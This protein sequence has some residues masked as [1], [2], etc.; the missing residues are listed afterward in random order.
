MKQPSDITDDFEGYANGL[1]GTLVQAVQQ[2][3]ALPGRDDLSF[4]RMLNRPLGTTLDTCSGDILDLCNTLMQYVGRP[5]SDPFEEAE[6]VQE[7]FGDVVDVVD[8]LL[9]KTD[10]CLDEMAGRATSRTAIVQSAPTL[11]KMSQPNLDYHLIHAQNIVRPQIR[12]T[13]K[14]DNTNRVPFVPKITSKPNA[15]VPLGY[16]SAPHPY[17][18]EIK[19]I[20]YPQRLFEPQP[21]TPYTP[22][23]G[24]DAV[25]IDTPAAFHAMVRSLEQASEIAVD[26]EAHDYRS[27][28]G[29]TCLMQIS[30]RTQDYIVDTLALRDEMQAINTVFT[31]SLIMKVFHG[32]DSDIVWLQRDFGV[33]VVGLFD[34]YQASRLLAFE[35]LSLAHLLQKYAKVTPDKRYQ[36]ADWRIRPLP[37]EM[38]D[39]AR[40]DTHYLL[41]IFDELRA[42]LLAKSNP[43][44]LNLMHAVLD[45]S[46]ETALKRYEKEMYDEEHGEGPGGWRTLLGK[47]NYTFNHVQLAA[48]RAL[49]AWRDRIART[50]DES[51]RYVLPNPMLFALAQKMPAEAAGVIGCCNPVPPLVRM[52]AS[53]IA[54]EIQ[55]ARVAAEQQQMERAAKQ[56]SSS[57]SSSSTVSSSM[58]NDRLMHHLP[59]FRLISSEKTMTTTDE[60]AWTTV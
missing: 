55:N 44:T 21:A 34:T 1:F 19:H 10:V 27:F 56:A 16:G 31:N 12:F 54:Y 52:N 41:Y 6:D 37:K 57:S 53:D 47:W 23:D 45:R 17:E 46:Q 28:Q 38:L 26:L 51:T 50:E 11:A 29:F 43:E 22:I 59:D 2:A 60:Q 18:Y 32:A 48:F 49:H 58:L 24:T 8:S 3:N 5:P 30:T 39:Y 25:W 7:R 42:E 40:S 4:Y 36:L 20:S 9:E 14:I 15:Q 33:Y 13:D 35:R